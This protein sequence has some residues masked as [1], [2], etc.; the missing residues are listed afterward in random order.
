MPSP[1]QPPRP[2][3]ANLPQTL[4]ERHRALQAVRD[5]VAELHVVPPLPLA[6]LRRHADRVI[7]TLRCDPAHRD[8]LAVL[9][10]NELWRDA[11]AATPFERRL[12]LLPKCLRPSE[13]CRAP[14]DALGLL[15]E[16]CGQCAIDGLQ[17]EAERLGYSVLVAEGSAVVM[18]LIQAKKVEALLGVSCLNVLERA[19]AHME[20]AALPGVAIPL[21]QDD[22]KETSV[23]VEW[24]RDYLRLFHPDPA[25]RLDL[26]ALRSEI[27]G[28]FTPE[29][30]D[31]LAGPAQG[32]SEAVARG[33]LLSG[34][35]RWRPLLCAGV[36][37]ALQGDASVPFPDG[38]KQIALA[39]E[40]FHKASLIHDDI[41]DDDPERYGAPA[42]HAEHG[43]G[44]ALNAGDFLIGEGYRLLA[45]A[46]FSAEQKAAMIHHAAEGQRQLCRGQGEELC[47][48]RKREPF[49]PEQVLDLF[50]HK[51]APAFEVALQLGALA[52]GCEP[53]AAVAPVLMAYS[54]ALGV[55]YQI[56]DDLED[57]DPAAAPS[58][59][60]IPALSREEVLRWLDDYKTEAVRALEP[61]GNA[62]LKGLLRRVVGRIFNETE[63]NTWCREIQE[64]RRQ[65]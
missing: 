46:P 39:V 23:D 48:R 40:C 4:E 37:Q 64:A 32:R 38:V 59:G 1:N 61:L 43:L 13:T 65:L 30:L 56:R 12:L 63:W 2:P 50:R 24:V 44:V 14:F 31:A 11:F 52:A 47:W 20:A 55:A 22:C 17:S 29:S 28:W 19:F 58:P 60:L 62:A 26:D 6:E 45:A 3:K 51:T 34:G 25:H 49:T 36:F 27:A 21:L 9:L 7:E 54:R 53:H 35:K 57:A 41:E 18:A 42:L 8:Y 16:R 33:W 15:C 10:N 5:Y